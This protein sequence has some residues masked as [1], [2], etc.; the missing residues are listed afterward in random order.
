MPEPRFLALIVFGGLGLMAMRR[1]PQPTV[2]KGVLGIWKAR[3]L[4]GFK[5]P[6]QSRD[7]AD[8]VNAAQTCN[9]SG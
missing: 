7:F 8:T 5:N 9:T 6:G 1:M 3:R 4:T 2:R